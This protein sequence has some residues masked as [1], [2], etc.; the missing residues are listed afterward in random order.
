MN[1]NRKAN[2]D[3]LRLFLALS[4]FH[5]HWHELIRV[6][7]LPFLL[8]PPVSC[9]V[10]LSGFLIPESLRTSRSPAHFWT[11]RALR[12]AP[13]FLLSLILVMTFF[14]PRALAPVL[15]DYISLGFVLWQ[16]LYTPVLWSL[17]LE[18]IL[19]G[20]VV[21]LHLCRAWKKSIVWACFIVSSALW[22][23]LFTHQHVPSVYEQWSPANTRL[24]PVTA[25]FAGNLLYLYKEQITVRRMLY[26]VP[27]ISLT[28]LLPGSLTYFLQPLYMTAFMALI[29]AML[30]TLPQVKLSFPDISYGIYIYHW[31]LMVFLR[32]ARIATGEIADAFYVLAFSAASWFLIEKPALALK[33]KFA[34]PEIPEQSE[35]VLVGNR[36]T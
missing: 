28:A 31:P 6:P 30:Y 14:G 16:P 5:V 12:I 9:F 18:E 19:Y 20:V 8:I 22:C 24:G 10:C 32:D 26:G 35:R 27:L 25:F 7:P 36:P 15:I 23:A 13:A 1:S 4:V 2:L 33:K 11:K 34:R 21:V 3:I 17:F 29:V